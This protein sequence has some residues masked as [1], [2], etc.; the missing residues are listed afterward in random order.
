MRPVEPTIRPDLL[1]EPLTSCQR[2]A[3][4]PASA[5]RHV[6]GLVRSGLR[7]AVHI[8]PHFVR[9]RPAASTIPRR[10]FEG[11]R[12]SACLQRAPRTSCEA[13]P[14]CLFGWELARQKV[15]RRQNA[16]IALR[17]GVCSRRNNLALAGVA[18][19]GRGRGP[20]LRAAL[21]RPRQLG[22]AQRRS[23]LLLRRRSHPRDRRVADAPL[24]SD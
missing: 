3:R 6:V 18:R 4:V 15:A 21:H 8:E 24:H 13:R 19:L 14:S 1:P 23:D 20:L 11:S 16:I 12:D 7:R 5:Q 10:A 9:S 22:P 2:T 17:R